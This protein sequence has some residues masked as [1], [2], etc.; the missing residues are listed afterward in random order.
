MK[1]W[2][3]AA[4][5]SS[6]GEEATRL[7]LETFR[8]NGALLTTGDDLASEFGLTS[9]RWQV[10]GAVWDEPRT[11]SGI[12][13]FMGLTRQSVQRTVR[14]LEKDGF[15][16]LEDNPEHKTARLVKLTQ[17]G[18]DTLDALSEKQAKWVSDLSEGM[19]PANIRIAVG[20]MRGLVG[21]LTEKGEG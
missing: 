12:A 3:K 18:V 19:Q 11:V 21:R 9:S 2:E 4:G 1:V 7:I 13:R 6:S 10:L 17:H 8:L 16:T 20:V 14:R 15:V 5:R